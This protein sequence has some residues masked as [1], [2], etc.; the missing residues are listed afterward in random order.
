MPQNSRYGEVVLLAGVAFVT[1]WNYINTVDTFALPHKTSLYSLK[2]IFQH[3]QYLTAASASQSSTQGDEFHR[4]LFDAK[5]TPTAVSGAFNFHYMNPTQVSKYVLGCYGTANFSD[6]QQTDPNSWHV[7]VEKLWLAGHV[8][9]AKINGTKFLNKHQKLARADAKSNNGGVCA[10]IDNVVRQAWN[11]EPTAYTG[12]HADGVDMTGNLYD[13]K[14]LSFESEDAVSNGEFYARTVE[15]CQQSAVPMFTIQ[16][17]G[18]IGIPV[19][20]LVAQMIILLGLLHAWDVYVDKDENASENVSGKVEKNPHVVR[21]YSKVTFAIA[22]FVGYMY[23]ASR[24]S[25]QFGND[26]PH[27]QG[28]R[29]SGRTQA[30]WTSSNT[31]VVVLLVLMLLIEFVFEYTSANSYAAAG[32]RQPQSGVAGKR[33]D[34][35]SCMIDRVGAD[36]PFIIGFALLGMCVLLQADVTNSTSVIGGVFILLTA[37]LLQHI[38]NLAKILYES[39]CFRLDARLI[40]SLALLDDKEH[41]DPN[42]NVKTFL[43]AKSEDTYATIKLRHK[44]RKLLQFFGWS[45]LYLFISVVSLS[46]AFFT[47]A[48][49]TSHVYVVKNILDGQL[50]L[51]VFAFLF[52]NIGFDMM[53]ELMPFTFEKVHSDTMRL[54][55]I[56]GY[57]LIFNFNQLSYMRSMHFTGV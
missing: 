17:E 20:L 7:S 1:V 15:F 4:S 3:D 34:L 33:S 41:D 24:D 57:L 5:Y 30:A 50:L 11:K 38:S 8:T 51:F 40:A 39:I 44:T 19:L 29:M 43:S 26:N 36:V 55:F 14:I 47:I 23:L 49:D 10:C 16:Y 13:L 25:N 27:F 31:V 32:N 6:F 48:R 45:R 28:F 46:I 18:T 35:V 37:G 12:V 42:P 22:I 53:Y 9:S 21:R 54:Y 52:S 2:P 56:V